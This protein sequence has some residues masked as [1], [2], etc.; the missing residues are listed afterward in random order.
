LNAQGPVQNPSNGHFYE[1]IISVGISWS[2]AKATA[3][4]M[5]HMGHAGH[6]VTLTSAAENSWVYTNLPT[7]L[8]R[9]WLGGFQDK[10]SPTYLEPSKGWTWVTGERW[11]FTAWFPGEPNNF[12]GI[13]DFLAFD[14]N[15]PAWNDILDNWTISG[16]FIVEYEDAPVIYCT[17]KVNSCVTTPAMS[18][19]GQSSASA[20][21]GFT[22]QASQ[23]KAQKFGLLVYG[24]TGRANL[25]FQGGI[26]CI[27]PPVRRAIAVADTVG[28]PPACNG[29]LAMDMNGF[30]AGVLGGNPQ[31]ALLVPGTLVNCQFWGRDTPGNSLLSN[32]L[33]YMVGA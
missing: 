3:E 27:N 20:T 11:V 33:E 15:Q 1:R 6:L 16:G 22:L 21:G 24:T 5:S 19:S 31:P 10:N 13:E 8:N 4:S 9:F 14:H 12:G 18:Y 26:L 7:S 25:P 2:A 32:A 29:V 28:T 23:T 17:G 30:A